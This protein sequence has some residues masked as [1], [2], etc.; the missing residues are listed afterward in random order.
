[1]ELTRVAPFDARRQLDRQAGAPGLRVVDR[2][3]A[4]VARPSAPAVRPG[5]SVPTA[6]G[7][8]IRCRSGC[9]TFMLMPLIKMARDDS[10]KPWGGFREGAGRPKAAHRKITPHRTRPALLPRNPV[11]VVLRRA[12]GA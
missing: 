10:K 1:M 8:D 4:R 11:H 12:G 3:A 6:R 5:R 7:R 9:Q 2:R